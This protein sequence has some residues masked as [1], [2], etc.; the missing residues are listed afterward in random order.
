MAMPP[1]F[2][3]LILAEVYELDRELSVTAVAVGSI[4]LL[5]TLPIWLLLFGS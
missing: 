5:L 1:A 4:S 3:T 2:A